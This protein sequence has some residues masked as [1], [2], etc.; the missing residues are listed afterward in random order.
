[1]PPVLNE[2]ELTKKPIQELE[3][4]LDFATINKDMKECEIARI[5]IQARADIYSKTK[6]LTTISDNIAKLQAVID[7]KDK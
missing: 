6:E 4:M 1:M 3:D 7:G 5:P 2:E